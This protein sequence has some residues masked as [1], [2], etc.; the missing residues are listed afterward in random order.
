ML[1]ARFLVVAQGKNNYAN[2]CKRYTDESRLEI[3]SPSLM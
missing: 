2:A 1:I 3:S